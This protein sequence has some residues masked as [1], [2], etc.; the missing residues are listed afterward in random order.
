MDFDL[1]YSDSL[2]IEPADRPKIENSYILLYSQD[3]GCGFSVQSELVLLPP[4]T[5]IFLPIDAN[6]EKIE[7]DKRSFVCI[8]FS[9]DFFDEKK[10]DLVYISI[11][12][13]FERSA[14]DYKSIELTTDKRAHIAYIFEQIRIAQSAKSADLYRELGNN[15]I[16]Q[17]LL[18]LALADRELGAV[19]KMDWSE[20]QAVV[21]KFLDLIESEVKI[22]KQVTYYAE[23]LNITPKKLTRLTKSLKSRSPKELI[24]EEVV[25]QSTMLLLHSNKSIKQIAWEM[26]Y[27]EEN[28]F[29]TLFA[30]ECGL[31]PSAFRKKN[32][33]LV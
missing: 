5:F 20:D 17:L 9:G 32:R 22:H 15:A 24:L 3:Q 19:K 33:G 6:V 26:G 28:N 11:R 1:E 2:I 23:S 21:N 10:D 14:S 27:E 25:K 12:S 18:I 4:F 30:K 7:T 8:Y 31:R 16:R 13:L 29:S